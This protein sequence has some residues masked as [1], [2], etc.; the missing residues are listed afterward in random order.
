MAEPATGFN[1]KGKSDKE[2]ALLGVGNWHWSFLHSIRTQHAISGDRQR[3]SEMELWRIKVW[4]TR[5]FSSQPKKNRR[6]K[7]AAVQCS[8]L[9]AEK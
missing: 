4:L 2:L 7:L 3:A 6:Q 8:T 9:A 5:V 1:V